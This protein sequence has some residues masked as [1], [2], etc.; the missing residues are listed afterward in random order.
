MTGPPP[1]KGTSV[2]FCLMASMKNTPQSCDAAPRP[3]CAKVTLI[4]ARFDIS[5]YLAQCVRRVSRT[6]DDCH[7]D[8]RDDADGLEVRDRIERQLAIKRDR[9]R[10]TEMV[11]E[12]GVSVGIGAHNTIAADRAACTGNVLHHD[13]LA[14]YPAHAFRR[15]P[16]D[17][18]C[19]PAGCERHDHGD[20]PLRKVLS[21]CRERRSRTIK[22]ASK[23]A[24]I[25]C[26]P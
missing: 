22:E 19:R 21:G 6:C 4:A 8:V 11:Q 1:R 20:W 3:E 7:V 5:Y 16:R 13:C 10:Q 23:T 18:V 24:R 2:T 17:C 14:E 12:D 26:L 25:V 15:N 9:S